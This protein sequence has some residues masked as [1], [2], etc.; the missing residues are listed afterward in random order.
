MKRTSTGIAL[1][2]AAI[3]GA[4]FS[5]DATAQD[6]ASGGYKIGVVD[7]KLVMR[8]YNKRQQKY[9][10][11]E[12]EVKSRQ[13]KI[14]GLSNEIEADKKRYTEMR[15]NPASN[16]DELQRLESDIQ[17]KYTQ[18]KADMENLQ[19]EIDTLEEN[20]LREVI[21]DVDAQIQSIGQS[22]NFHLL[23][24]GSRGGGVVYHSTAIDITSQVTSALNGGASAA[25]AVAPAAAPAEDGKKKKRD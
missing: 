25:P 7:V 19:R 6:A 12:T 2:L 23:L 21:A 3:I 10:Q 24:N 13:S 9:S 14:D 5:L 17:R 4:G 8:D 1:A 15:E 16:A 22:Q 20:V 18:Y 11:L